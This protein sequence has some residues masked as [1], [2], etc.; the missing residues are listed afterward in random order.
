MT[1]NL[2]FG[3]SRPVVATMT[4]VAPVGLSGAGLITMTKTTS[5]TPLPTRPSHQVLGSTRVRP[6]RLAPTQTIA[7]L[8]GLATSLH[9]EGHLEQAE[10]V[11]HDVLEQDPGNVDASHLLGVLCYQRG[12]HD[13]AIEWLQRAAND[14]QSDPSFFMHLGE[15]Y[16]ALS[17]FDEAVASFNRALALEPHDADTICNLGHA[18]LQRGAFED[19][20]RCYRDVLQQFP[21]DLDAWRAL[22]ATLLHLHRREDATETF[23]AVLRLCP[24]DPEATHMLAAARGETPPHAA[25]GYVERL[26]D[27]YADSFERHLVETLRYDV[28]RRLRRLIDQLGVPSSARIVDLGCGTGLCGDAVRSMAGELVGVDLASRMVERARERG[29]YDHVDQSDA[30]AW[31][32]RHPGAADVVLAADVIIY[33]GDLD[34]LLAAVR[35]ALVPGGVF[36]LSIETTTGRPYELRETGRYAHDPADVRARA[37]SHGLSLSVSEDVVIRF[38]RGEPIEGQVMAF[39]KI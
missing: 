37:A 31:L 18:H 27:R 4:V 11:Y 10:R 32:Q 35:D 2:R 39:R 13:V 6:R 1:A 30:T 7:A 14:K 17:R 38:D 16:R 20:E 8:L 3:R 25:P 21:D 12:Q 22:G 9:H 33:I 15:V 29:V 23:E 19:A 26:F 24:D 28:P 36:G 5:D 34:D